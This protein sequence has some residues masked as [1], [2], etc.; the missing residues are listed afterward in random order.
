MRTEAEIDRDARPG[1]AFSNGTEWECWSSRWC[2][3][4]IHDEWR[5]GKFC[6]LVNVA[7]LGDKTPLE[8][9]NERPL[10][11]YERYTCIEFRAE[12]GGPDPTPRPIPDPPDQEVLFPREQAEGFRM[13]TTLPSRQEVSAS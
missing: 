7:M 6:P 10:S 5:T 4:C 3:R 9:M 13:L 2:N 11:L 1:S 12:D 8:W